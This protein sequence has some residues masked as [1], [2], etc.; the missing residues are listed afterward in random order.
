MQPSW[1]QSCSL[2]SAPVSPAVNASHAATVDQDGLVSVV[3]LTG[4]AMAWQFQ[5][6]RGYQLNPVALDA[7]GAVY[8]ATYDGF[9]VCAANQALP[10]NP[11]VDVSA[12]ARNGAGVLTPAPLYSETFSGNDAW[13][14]SSFKSTAPGLQGSG[15]RFNELTSGT[16]GQLQV[17]PAIA[18]SGPYDVYV[19]W[20]SE[21]NAS[22]VAYTVRHLGGTTTVFRDQIPAGA[23]GGSNAN[24]WVYLGRFQFAAGSNPATGSLAVDEST[25]TGPNQANQ[26]GGVSSDGFLWVNAPGPSRSPRLES[27]L[28]LCSLQ[29]LF[30]ATVARGLQSRDSR[31]QA[32]PLWR[33]AL[34]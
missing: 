33:Q 9:L 30:K 11:V 12:E 13:N 18:T 24:T 20:T 27:F 21:G 5:A 15:S 6:A 4:G 8:A 2:D 16:T 7:S 14:N 31:K 17:A 28:T 22:H 10:A 23:P 3:A 26:R 32:A 29:E 25:V 1:S 19:S 34:L